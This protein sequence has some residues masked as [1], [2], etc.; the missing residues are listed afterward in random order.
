ME[1]ICSFIQEAPIA[2][3]RKKVVLEYFRNKTLGY[4]DEGKNFKEQLTHTS[5]NKEQSEQLE[6]SI[7]IYV[8]VKLQR[9]EDA[10]NFFRS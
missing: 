10:N 9:Q 7:L 1:G 4:N 6:S 3:I 8:T 5:S 2:N